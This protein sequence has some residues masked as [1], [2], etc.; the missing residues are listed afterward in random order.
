MKEGVIEVSECLKLSKGSARFSSWI[1]ELKL[2]MSSGQQL[3]SNSTGKYFKIATL[4]LFASKLFQ[5]I[6]STTTT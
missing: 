6:L 1:M 5:Q 4:K 3:W 2:D